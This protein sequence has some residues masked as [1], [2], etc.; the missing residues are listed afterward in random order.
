MG[1]GELIR[2]GEGGEPRVY[3]TMWMYGMLR[4]GGHGGRAGWLVA[5]GR[6]TGTGARRR[7]TRFPQ[8]LGRRVTRRGKR[9]LSDGVYVWLM[10]GVL[11]RFVQEVRAAGLEFPRIQRKNTDA[12]GC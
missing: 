9:G 8:E 11:T 7:S 12:L 10:Y 2:R 3:L 6:R 4:A 1:G 5:Y